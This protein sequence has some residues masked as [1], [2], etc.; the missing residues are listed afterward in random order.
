MLAANP[1]SERRFQSTLGPSQKT[2]WQKRD[3]P[4]G[5]VQG[6]SGRAKHTCIRGRVCLVRRAFGAYGV[7]STPVQQSFAVS[8]GS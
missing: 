6:P 7:L 3:G 2:P 4:L 8:A 5:D 1:M